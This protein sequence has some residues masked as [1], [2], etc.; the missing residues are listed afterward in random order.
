MMFQLL[1]PWAA[2]QLFV[3]AGTIIDGNDPMWNGN[4]LPLPMPLNAK[5]LDQ[6]AYDAMVAWYT[7]HLIDNFLH[8]LHYARGIQ[9]K[10]GN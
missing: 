5:A 1:G 9:P 3:P 4:P 8:L 6:D 10:K 7:P 2:G